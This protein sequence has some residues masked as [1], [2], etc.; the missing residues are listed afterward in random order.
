[1]ACPVPCT[2]LRTCGVPVVIPAVVLP[3]EILDSAPH[4]L[5][6]IRVCP[7]VRID[8]VDGVVDGVMRVT[9]RTKIA[10]CAPS[11]TNDRSAGFDGHE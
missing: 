4:A 8:K 6:G 3:E 11:I 1:V 7:G 2:S 10:V 9:L 5:G